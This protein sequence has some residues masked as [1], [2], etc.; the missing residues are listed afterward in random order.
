MLRCCGLSLQ[1]SGQAKGVL[2]AREAPGEEQQ[3]VLRSERWR[4]G[5]RKRSKEPRNSSRGAAVYLVPDPPRECSDDDEKFLRFD[6]LRDV[7]LKACHE[8]A[9]FRMRGGCGGAVARPHERLA[10]AA[11]LSRTSTVIR[12]RLRCF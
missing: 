5:V 4:L 12:A 11:G 9:G 2:A 3:D 8:R 6:R 10:W 7:R 1:P